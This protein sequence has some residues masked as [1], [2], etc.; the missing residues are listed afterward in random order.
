MA[1]H[2]FVIHGYLHPALVDGD[3]YISKASWP[4]SSSKNSDLLLQSVSQSSKAFVHIG[5][6]VHILIYVQALPHISHTLSH[7]HIYLHTQSQTC[8]PSHSHL[9]IYL[10]S[11]IHTDIQD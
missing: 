8:S 7:S 9:H 10:H 5:T 11:H 4:P 3:R 1:T 6:Y 2:I